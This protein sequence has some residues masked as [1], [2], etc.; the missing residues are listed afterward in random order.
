M[1]KTCLSILALTA[2]FLSSCQ[3]EN[4]FQTESSVQ[5]IRMC[6][7]D[8]INKITD[9]TENTTKAVLQTNKKWTT[10]STIRIKFLN[11]TNFLQSKVKEFANQWTKYANLKFVWVDSTADSDVKVAFNWNGDTGSWS[12]VGTDCRYI[13]QDQPSMNFGWFTNQTADSEFSRTIIHEFGH[14]LALKH[15]QQHPLNT[16]SWNKPVVYAYYAQF[17]WDK[18]LVDRSVFLKLSAGSTNYSDYDKYSIMHY[19]LSASFTT[20]GYSVGLNT[21]LSDMDKQ[22]IATQYKY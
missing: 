3:Q 18:E 20:N 10:G 9:N 2:V 7:F 6:T 21:V 1:K 4:S 16:I 12:Y 5:E 8:Q 11:G 13:S 22:F 14:A 17:G 15:E 19:S